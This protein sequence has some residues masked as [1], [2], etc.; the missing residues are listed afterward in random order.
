MQAVSQFI[1][2]V[3]NHKQ[4]SKLCSHFAR[5]VCSWARAKKEETSNRKKEG[6]GMTEKSSRNKDRKG[7][8][9]TEGMDMYTAPSGPC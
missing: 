8:R 5:D 4:N 6:E 2:Q 9:N 7:K 1:K 3:R